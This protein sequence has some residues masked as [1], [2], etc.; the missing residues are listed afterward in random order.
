[1]VAMRA[2]ESG[3]QVNAALLIL[4]TSQPASEILAL[5]YSTQRLPEQL[6]QAQ[7]S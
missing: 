7:P 4:P 5:R 3:T 6:H 2:C 1:M